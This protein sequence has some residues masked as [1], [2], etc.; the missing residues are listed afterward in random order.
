MEVKDGSIDFDQRQLQL[1]RQKASRNALARHRPAHQKS[2][3]IDRHFGRHRFV[4]NHA[5]CSL[6]PR[7]YD[8]TEGTVQRGRR[9]RAGLR[10]GGPAQSGGRGAAKERAVLRHHQGEPALG[11]PERHRRAA[12]SRP[13]AW[14]RQTSLSSSSRE[15]YDTYIEQGGTNVSGGQKQRLCIARALAEEAQD[16]DFGRL[17]QRRGYPHRRPHPPGAS[18]KFIPETTKII[19]AQRVASVQDAD[20]IIVMNNGEIDAIG[21]P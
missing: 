11:Q 9:G 18:A 3:E 6:I 17:H 12:G 2:G 7:L 1:L 19:I 4:Q 5:W 8:A 20:R 16:S 10:L 21:T 14:P 15:K 13:A